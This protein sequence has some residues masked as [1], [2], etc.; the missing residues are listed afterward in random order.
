MSDNDKATGSK[1]NLNSELSKR[2]LALIRNADF[3]R[4]G[5]YEAIDLVMSHFTRDPS[6]AILDLGCGLGGTADYIQR[7][8]W[9]IVSGVDIDPSSIETARKSIPT[10]NL[11]VARL[12]S[13]VNSPLSDT[14]SFTCFPSF[15]R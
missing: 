8:G 10:T 9:G 13:L 3:A 7:Q 12:K 4:P 5:E 14:T 6:R 2:A 15:M 1:I 11:S